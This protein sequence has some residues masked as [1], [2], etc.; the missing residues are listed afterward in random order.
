MDLTTPFEVLKYS[1]AGFDYPTT[2]FCVLIPQ[3]EQELRRSCLGKPLFDFMVSKLTPYPAG[4]LEWDSAVSYA[5][6]DVVIRNGCTFVSTANSNETDPLAIGADWSEFERFTD[7]GAN[8]LWSLYLRQIMA[9]KV[10]M[11]SLTSTTFR[12]G[13]GGIVVGSGDGSGFR[14]ANKGEI[15]NTKQE[16]EAFIRMTTDNMVEWLSDNYVA[17]GLPT[18]ICVTGCDTTTNRSRRWAFRT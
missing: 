8:E 14:S 17:K 6:D 2:N 15:L 10:Y 3:F 4:L 18:P 11:A 1:P 13:A 9:F 5:L 16:L 7:A 12:A